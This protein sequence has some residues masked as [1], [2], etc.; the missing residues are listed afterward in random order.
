MKIL[1][2]ILLFLIG[3]YVGYASCGLLSFNSIWEASQE[4]YKKKVQREKMNDK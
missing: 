3:V 1:I 2:Y 4:A